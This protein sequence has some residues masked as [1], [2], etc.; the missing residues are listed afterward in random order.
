MKEAM[1]VGVSRAGVSTVWIAGLGW[2]DMIE[3]GHP[4]IC[5]ERGHDGVSAAIMI[6]CWVM[7][8]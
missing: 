5:H 4:V 3:W 2:L 6:A 8:A 1:T 7:R